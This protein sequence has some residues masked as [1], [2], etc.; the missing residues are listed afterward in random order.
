MINESCLVRLFRPWV[1]AQIVVSF[2]QE[3]LLDLCMLEGYAGGG[4]GNLNNLRRAQLLQSKSCQPVT[5][6]DACL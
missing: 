2:V 6:L 1:P 4:A 5:F 3:C